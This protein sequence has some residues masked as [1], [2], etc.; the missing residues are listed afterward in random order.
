[1][2]YRR[3]TFKKACLTLA[4]C[5]SRRWDWLPALCEMKNLS[6]TNFL[7]LLGMIWTA[8]DNISN[9]VDDYELQERV[10][11]AVA[12]PLP[13]GKRPSF[14]MPG[15]EHIPLMMT[16]E[17]LSALLALP[18]QVTIYRG[19]G[20]DNMY[21]VSW[22]LDKNVAMCFPYK[23]L[24]VQSEPLLITAK[25]DRKDIVALKLG[26]DESEVIVFWVREYVKE[27][28]ELALPRPDYPVI[29]I[30]ELAESYAMSSPYSESAAA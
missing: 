1:M 3:T 18:E 10:H 26:C 11:T 30:D 12:P 24:Y 17:E 2:K 23:G 27:F 16:A 8:C 21:G 4:R 5:E 22:T 13:W 9:C 15:T 25:I 19:C 20:P 6:R 7:R 29:P 28:E 14:K